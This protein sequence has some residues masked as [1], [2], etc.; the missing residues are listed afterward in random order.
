MSNK[1]VRKNYIVRAFHTTIFI[2]FLFWIY[3]A[4]FGSYAFPYGLV[5]AACA[6]GLLFMALPEY[7]KMIRQKPQSVLRRRLVWVVSTLTLIVVLMLLWGVAQDV[8]GIRC[9]G[10]F[11]VQ[12]SCV[13]S[14]QILLVLTALN[15]LVF[16]PLA[17][18]LIVAFIYAWAADPKP[19]A[20]TRQSPQ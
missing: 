3:C 9:T 20:P 17:A 8:M 7:D 13:T 16:I 12:W 4:A 1:K 6:L 5:M 19:P 11:G 18:C 14:A 15:P 2:G 10:F